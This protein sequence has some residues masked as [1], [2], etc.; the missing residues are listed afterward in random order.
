[1]PRIYKVNPF[2]GTKFFHTWRNMKQRCNNEK[3]PAFKNYGGRGIKNEWKDFEQFRL[4]MLESYQE[5]EKE[6]PGEEILLD[7]IDNNSNYSKTNCRWTNRSEQNRNKRSNIFLTFRGETLILTDMAKK[8]GL[9]P[10]RVLQRLKR[11]KWSVEKALTTP[12]L[13]KKYK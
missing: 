2:L 13:H 6:H 7:R 3:H 1:M 4:E 10:M 8:Y 12:H 5:Y 11:N 9:H